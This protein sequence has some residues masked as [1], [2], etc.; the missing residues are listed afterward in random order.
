MYEERHVVSHHVEC[1]V[2]E[3]EMVARSARSRVPWVHN[4]PF[5]LHCIVGYMRVVFYSSL[6]ELWSACEVPIDTNNI[7]LFHVFT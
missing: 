7:S 6:S 5:D 1:I 3:P 4:E 2:S